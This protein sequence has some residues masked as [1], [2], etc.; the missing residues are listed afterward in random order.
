MSDLQ[1]Y[2]KEVAEHSWDPEGDHDRT[3]QEVLVAGVEYFED[4]D[5]MCRSICASANHRIGMALRCN[6]PIPV[7]SEVTPSEMQSWLTG[8]SEPSTG[9]VEVIGE[10][11]YQHLQGRYREELGL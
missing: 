9:Q 8:D 5:D 4:A 2:L 6:L 3:F 1:A 7:G 10:Y 11:I